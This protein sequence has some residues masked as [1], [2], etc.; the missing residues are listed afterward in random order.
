MSH[1]YNARDNKSNSIEPAEVLNTTSTL[2][3]LKFL[4]DETDMVVPRSFVRQGLVKN[5]AD[6]LPAGNDEL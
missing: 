3:G 6:Y 2:V 1:F 5:V 4:T